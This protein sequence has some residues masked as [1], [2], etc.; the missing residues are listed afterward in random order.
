MAPIIAKDAPI[1]GG[2][3]AYGQSALKLINILIAQSGIAGIVDF[4]EYDIGLPD[5]ISC[6]LAIVYFDANRDIEE[7]KND[8]ALLK[9]V[10]GVSIVILLAPESQSR[11]INEHR[12]D[13]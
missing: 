9:I 8:L 7:Y 3:F 5:S 1:Q 11:V 4:K 6:E 13:L 10:R 12:A 2:I